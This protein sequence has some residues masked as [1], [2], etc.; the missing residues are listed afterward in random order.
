MTAKTVAICVALILVGVLIG[1]VGV[2]VGTNVRGVYAFSSIASPVVWRMNTRT[3]EM[4]VCQSGGLKEPATCGQ[5][6]PVG[7]R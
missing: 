4:S 1:M 7:G 6:G 5:W 3:G 2:L